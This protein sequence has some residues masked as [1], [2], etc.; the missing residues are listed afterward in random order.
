M[1]RNEKT[2]LLCFLMLCSVVALGVSA[3]FKSLDKSATWPKDVAIAISLP[4]A[5]GGLI[6][7]LIPVEKPKRKRGRS[8]KSCSGLRS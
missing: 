3:Y 4:C 7:C 5:G 6:A 1:K 2:A 8:K